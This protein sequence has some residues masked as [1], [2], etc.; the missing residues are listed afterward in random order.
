MFPGLGGAMTSVTMVRALEQIG[1]LGSSVYEPWL[2]GGPGAYKGLRI[3]A[4]RE[5]VVV[6]KHSSLATSPYNKFAHG[7]VGQLVAATSQQHGDAH[8]FV[9][10]VESIAQAPP[11]RRWLE[12]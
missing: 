10:G 4:A 11:T 1:L 7:V 9:Q 2:V 8:P 12:R 3:A 6:P 5:T